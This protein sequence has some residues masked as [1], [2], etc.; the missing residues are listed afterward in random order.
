MEAL[1]NSATPD[2][3]HIQAYADD[4]V[5]SVFGRSCNAL[6]TRSCEALNQ[7]ILQLF[8]IVP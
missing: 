6:K 5:L 2:Y 1:F 7:I 8:E 3:V 4:I